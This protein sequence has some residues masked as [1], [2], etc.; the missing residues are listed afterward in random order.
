MRPYEFNRWNPDTGARKHDPD[1]TFDY[2]EK[3]LFRHL[4]S[5]AEVAAVFVV[6]VQGEGGYL[7]PPR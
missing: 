7:V 5:P 6:P 3:T 1:E 4:V 2:L